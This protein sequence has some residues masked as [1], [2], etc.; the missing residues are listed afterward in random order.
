MQ[1]CLGFKQSILQ[2]YAYLR[3]CLRKLEVWGRSSAQ[4]K[5]FGA[6]ALYFLLLDERFE[7]VLK[8]T[9][10]RF[11]PAIMSCYQLPL[12]MRKYNNNKKEF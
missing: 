11:R 2:D 4:E 7:E 3:Y 12:P 8:R 1:G 6:T 9:P 5:D 10:A